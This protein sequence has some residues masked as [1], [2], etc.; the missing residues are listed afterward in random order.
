MGKPAGIA[1]VVSSVFCCSDAWAYLDPGTGS[2]FFQ[3]ISAG[4]LATL[5]MVKPLW[6][7][8]RRTLT[9][10]LEKTRKR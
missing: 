6:R 10:I 1:I 3:I 5:F 2:Y 9:Q 8:V 4:L 7:H